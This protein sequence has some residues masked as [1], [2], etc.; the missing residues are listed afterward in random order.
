M[1]RKAAD[2]SSQHLAPAVNIALLGEL[3]IYVV[4]EHELDKIAE[5]SSASLAFNGAVALL[6]I[7]VAFL[8][9]LTTT[10][11]SKQWLSNVYL[12]VC[13][14]FLLVG[15]ILLIYW[16]RTRKSV[17]V[18]VRDIK[19]RMRTQPG[20]QEPMPAVPHPPIVE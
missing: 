2:Q 17:Q 18:L 8:L 15:S 1:A 5:G 16:W 14:N 19:G 9:T 13:I 6:S 11:I 20:I 3:N 7:G 4:H 12:F 10:T